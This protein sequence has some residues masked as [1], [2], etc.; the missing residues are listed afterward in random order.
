MKYMLVE[1]IVLLD[2][3]KCRSLYTPG[4]A[5]IGMSHSIVAKLLINVVLS[6]FHLKDTEKSSSSYAGVHRCFSSLST[7]AYVP[8]VKRSNLGFALQNVAVG[9]C[10][11]PVLNQPSFGSSTS[12]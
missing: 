12:C 2:D 1:F 11:L 9:F 7:K 10:L 8:S 4:S 3:P 5:S 6:N